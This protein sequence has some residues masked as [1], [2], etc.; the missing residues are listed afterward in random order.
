MTSTPTKD[1][2][3]SQRRKARGFIF[4]EEST[5]KFRRAIKR[6]QSSCNINGQIYKPSTKINLQY[7][8][9]LATAGG[10]MNFQC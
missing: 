10:K 2:K 6:L 5:R 3:R 4:L 8:D 1:S 9:L 7:T